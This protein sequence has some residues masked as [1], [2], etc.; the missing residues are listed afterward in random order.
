MCDSVDSL[1]LQSFPGS[2][3]GS[4]NNMVSPEKTMLV[5]RDMMVSDGVTT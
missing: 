2:V 3:N 5:P 1:S 4:G